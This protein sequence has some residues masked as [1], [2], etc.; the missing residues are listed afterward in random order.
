MIFCNLDYL[1]LNICYCKFFST[2]LYGLF[3]T[4]TFIIDNGIKH[5]VIL[6][7]ETI[8][9]LSCTKVYTETVVYILLCV[10]E[11]KLVF[12]LGFNVKF[13][14]KCKRKKY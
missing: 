14:L 3:W 8:I 5:D 1:S 12:Q 2:I 4:F 9:K 11:R 7:Y 6:A 10:I 13:R